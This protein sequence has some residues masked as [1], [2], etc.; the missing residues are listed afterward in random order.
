M[1]RGSKSVTRLSFLIRFWCVQQVSS[2]VSDFLTLS[3]FSV[4]VGDGLQV[5][6]ELMD[7]R[8]YSQAAQTTS[9]A[10]AVIPA[11]PKPAVRTNSLHLPD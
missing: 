9:P 11:P 6:Q 1:S 5:L 4:G 2:S 3:C 7:G 10:P 8:G